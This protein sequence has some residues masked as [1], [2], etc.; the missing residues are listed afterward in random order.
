MNSKQLSDFIARL[1][2]AG[3]DPN[4]HS[5]IIEILGIKP[6]APPHEQCSVDGGPNLRTYAA[7]P[8]PSA[9]LEAL[10]PAV[11]ACV[12]EVVRAVVAGS[13]PGQA[14]EVLC[15]SLPKLPRAVGLA[16]LDSLPVMLKVDG[17]E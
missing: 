13:T 6:P 9:G 4:K 17:D 12:V 16:L 3:I 2:A 8:G 11:V 5:R 10:V 15:K 7:A 14:A 1:T